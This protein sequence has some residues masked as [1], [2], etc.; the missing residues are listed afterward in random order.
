VGKRGERK[1]IKRKQERAERRKEESVKESIMMSTAVRCA[2]LSIRKGHP[3]YLLNKLFV[4]K[5]INRANW[6]ED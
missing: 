4:N 3:I 2:V 1:E 6:G 5:L